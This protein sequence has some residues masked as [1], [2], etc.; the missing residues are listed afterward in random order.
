M[1]TTDKDQDVDLFLRAW[2][3]EIS[4]AIEIF[5]GEKVEVGCRR[6]E[7]AAGRDEGAKCLWWKQD[8]ETDQPFTVWVGVEEA[9]WTALG[10]GNEP[11][12]RC[13]QI[14]F[15][16]LRQTHDAVANALGGEI[17]KPV[18]CRA[19]ETKEPER[20]PDLHFC[21]VE[22]SF[23]G[24]PL[25]PF[26]LAA[27]HTPMAGSNRNVGVQESGDMNIVKPVLTAPPLAL[28][29]LMELELPLAVSLGKAVMPIREI[30]KITP[31][32][33]IELDRTPADYV[34]LLVHGTVVARG[35]IVSVK[36]NYGVRIKE[37]ISREDRM[38][39]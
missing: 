4:R 28:G 8:F 10:G 31:G 11:D 25:P 18:R 34:D 26:L 1:P 39:L 7:R 15:D 6:R 37:I 35:E 2:Q 13:R 33:L 17:G 30:L 27:E 38:A 21:A 5:T 20:L 23:R 16:I 22:I 32:C 29:R 12:E 9:T 14:Y 36:G 24:Q 19:G 3:V